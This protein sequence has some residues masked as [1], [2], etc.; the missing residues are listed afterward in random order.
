MAKQSIPLNRY[1][2]PKSKLKINK[3]QNITQI[4]LPIADPIIE[5]TEATVEV[6]LSPSDDTSLGKQKGKE[7]TVGTPK[8]LKRKVGEGRS[9]VAV[10]L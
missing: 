6:Q 10:D 8:R 9:G 7:L 2:W 4:P 1:L 3:F 5:L